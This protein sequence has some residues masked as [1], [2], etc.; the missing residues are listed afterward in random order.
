MRSDLPVYWV[1]CFDG[2]LWQNRGHASFWRAS[3]RTLLERAAPEVIQYFVYALEKETAEPLAFLSRPVEPERQARLFA[4][5]R[6]LWCAAVLGVMSGREVVFDGSKWTSVLPPSRPGRRRWRA[7]T[8]VRV[9]RGGSIGQRCGCGELWPATGFA[10]GPA[11]RGARRG[12]IRA[13]Y[14]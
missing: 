10:Q 12:P 14:G 8:A 3:Q 1:P 5:T 4:G 11:I 13:R 6:N 2:G 9:F 7:E